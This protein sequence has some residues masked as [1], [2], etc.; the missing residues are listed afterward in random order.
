M[1]RLRKV[2]EVGSLKVD[3]GG[4]GARGINF[5]KNWWASNVHDPFLV[6]LLISMLGNLLSGDNTFKKFCHFIKI[7]FGLFHFCF[8]KCVSTC[9]NNL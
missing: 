2:G 5:D 6:S 7:T 3:K 9:E 8:S 1:R 4:E